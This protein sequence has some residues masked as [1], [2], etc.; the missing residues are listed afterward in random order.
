VAGRHGADLRYV[1]PWKAWLVWDGRR[2]TEDATAEPVRRV[3][4]AQG[5]FYRAVAARFGELPDAGDAASAERAELLKELNHA[6]RWEDARAIARC[7][8]LLKS[9]PG[10][11]ALPSELDRDL[12]LL[13]VLNGTLDLRTGR[14]RPHR[15]ADLLTKLAPVAYDPGA[16]CPLWLRFLDRI[17]RGNQD[18]VAYLQRVAGYAL[19]GE[20]SEQCL[21]FLYGTGANGKSTFLQTLLAVLGDYGMQAVSELLM[22]KNHESHPTERADLFG[23][24]FVATI[25]A[26]EGKRVAESLMKQLTGGD[27]VRARRMRQDFFEFDQTWKL[28]LA[29]NHKPN[30]RG[31]DHGVWRRIKLVPFAVTIPDEEKDK[32][33]PEKLRAE[34][35]GVLAWLVR[36]CLDWQR[37]GL[38]EPE[39]VKAA[40]DAYRSEQDSL[41]AF[42][43]ECCLVHPAVRSK[44]SD[45]LEAYHAWSGD[46]LM[47]R[48]AFNQR[49]RD[50]GFETKRGHGG[51]Y[52]WHGIGLNAGGAGERGEGGPGTF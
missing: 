6:V 19:T 48:Q 29:A 51:G 49:V 25:E 4:E 2:W 28:F 13:N 37:G 33:L 45:L 5:A 34:L 41:Q 31:T 50:K 20:V 42:L 40:T 38:G 24:R 39:E 43:N 16:A 52:F 14:L 46:R 47:S 15:R 17:M 23:K 21:W 22:A 10:V 1:H 12:Y 32:A 8:E 3:K 36:G 9:E 7:L 18:L 27:R 44:A 11:P 35:P 26:E 30:V